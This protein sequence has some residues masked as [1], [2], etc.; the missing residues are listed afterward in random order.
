MTNHNYQDCAK[1]LKTLS[2]T[3]RRVKLLTKFGTKLL[4]TKR[5]YKWIDSH[6]VKSNRSRRSK[7][8]FHNINCKKTRYMNSSIPK[9]IECLNSDPNF[10]LPYQYTLNVVKQ[11]NW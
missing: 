4:N 8:L 7:N 6:L 2:L 9:I 5:Y 10:K 11:N 3:D 1:E